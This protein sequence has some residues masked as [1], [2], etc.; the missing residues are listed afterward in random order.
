[1]L[2]LVSAEIYPTAIR[3][4]TYGWSPAIGK[5]GATT[6]FKPAVVALGGGDADKGQARVFILASG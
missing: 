4:T 2:R 3:D 6:A 1:M 5:S